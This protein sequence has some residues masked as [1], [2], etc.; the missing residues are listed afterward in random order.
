MTIGLPV[1]RLITANVNLQA[2]AAQSP[3]FNSCLILGTSP[4]I[5]TVSRFRNYSSLTDV[6]VD[7]D[8]ASE[9]YKAAALW[10]NQSPKPTSLLIG[11][12]AKTASAGKLIGAQLSAANQ[13]IGAWSAITNGAFQIAINGGAPAAI[14]GLNFSAQ[15][16]LNGVASVITAA[17]TGATCVYNAAY[18]RFEITS[19]TTGA[20]SSISFLAAPGAGTDISGM[21]GML[22]TSS[23]AYQA[24]GITAET[25]LQAVTLY[26]QNWSDQWY[27]LI[28][29]GAV[30]A[31][32]IAVA[33]LIEG[34]SAAHIYGVT[35][36]EAGVLNSG[37]TTNIAYV[38]KQLRYNHTVVQYSSS[39]P[40]AV[41]SL[42]ARILTTDWSANNTAITLMY[43]DE[44]EVVAE[45]L[46][47][48]QANNLESYNCNVFV[49]YNNSTAIIEPGV[50]A[51]GQFIDTIIGSDWLKT[52]IQA[53]TYTELR[54]RSTKIPQSDSGMHEIVTIIEAICSQ[55]VNNGLLAPGY[56]SG[57][58]FGQL[59]TGDFMP[60]GFYV[61]QP[62]LSSQSLADRQARKTV[63]FK[64]AAHLA[65][66][67]HSVDMEINVAA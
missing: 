48:T 41:A 28:I 30:D 53:D 50:T 42:L 44:P 45:T 63:R 2:V 38:L 32:H 24:S 55:G 1:S 8:G 49:A 20:T 23:G 37:D 27:G 62:P 36:S 25:A 39:S 61:Y 52:T 16:N 17:L 64:I 12:W 57:S 14:A 7:F 19:G 9:E 54:L 43:K 11:R 35:T 3:N 56:W 26:D 65:G 58:S 15:T 5:D 10:F 13:A 29:P 60:K 46:N 67:V 4:I 40:Y 34:A 47:N 59:K 6:G 66:A 33:G 21:M 22:S 18:K 31:D 51:S